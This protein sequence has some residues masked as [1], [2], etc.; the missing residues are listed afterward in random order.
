MFMLRQTSVKMAVLLH[1][2]ANDRFHSLLTV[3]RNLW[4]RKPKQKERETA[5]TDMTDKTDNEEVSG[6]A[7][8]IRTQGLVLT[9]F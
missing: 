6:P 1:K 4:V 5:K 9:K 8:R 2:Q 7:E 3:Y